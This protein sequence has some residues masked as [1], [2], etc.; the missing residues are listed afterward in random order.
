MASAFSAD[1]SYDI[2]IVGDIEDDDEG[3]GNQRINTSL[4]DDSMASL[5]ISEIAAQIEAFSHNVSDDGS[6]SAR[7]HLYGFCRIVAVDYC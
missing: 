5:S 4:T 1:R 2:G 6:F 3:A 7:G